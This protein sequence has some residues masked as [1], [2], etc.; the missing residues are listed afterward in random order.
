VRLVGYVIYRTFA[1]SDRDGRPMSE[2]H[3]VSYRELIE[4]A[5]ISRGALKEAIDQAIHGNLLQCVRH[6]RPSQAGADSESSVFELRWHDGEYSTDRTLF[7]GFFEGAGNRTYIPNQFFTRLLPNESLSVLKVVGSVIRFSIGFEVKRGFRRQQAALSYADIQRYSNIAGRHH[8]SRALSNAIASNYIAQIEKGV[9]DPNAGRASKAAVYGLKWTT[10]V[11]TAGESGSKKLPDETQPIMPVGSKKL[12]DNPF[13]KVT[14]SGSKG[15]PGDRSKKV[16]GIEIKQTNKTPKQQQQA[17]VAPIDPEDE[18]AHRRLI[19]I[20]FDRVTSVRLASSRSLEHIERQIAWMGQRNPTR[21]PLGML[22]RA[23]EEDWTEPVNLVV[24]ISTEHS[25]AAVFAR[26]FYAGFA[27]NALTPIATPSPADLA[28]ADPLVK[29]LLVMWPDTTQVE[30]WG[31]QFGKHAAE[32]QVPHQRPIGLLFAVRLLGDAF[33]AWARRDRD[34][35]RRQTA[36]AQREAHEALLK[37]EYLRYLQE[38]ES[39]LKKQSPDRYREFLTYR[40]EQRKKFLRFV[41]NGGQSALMR[42][43]ETEAA[44]L[45]DFRSFFTQDVLGFSAWEPR[46]HQQELPA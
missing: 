38:A 4:K 21:N 33:V 39:E 34:R 24:D 8:V 28:A 29:A 5:G 30:A 13:K 45:E 3:K 20:G 43:F 1:W 2:Q 22:R 18:G 6:G 37:S 32:Q 36:Q 26:H 27:D 12:P 10:D 15:E 35:H 44:R 11:R 14:G 17:A 31:R 46:R 9:F 7:Q 40:E 23:I 16:T 42:G 19:E 41:R 25:A